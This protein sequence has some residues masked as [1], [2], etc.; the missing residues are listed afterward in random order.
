SSG[1]LAEPPI[2]L[3]EVQ[4]YAYGAKLA[5]ARL[6]RAMDDEVAAARLEAEAAKLRDEFERAFWCQD[7]GV[8][9]LALD[10]E[11]RPCK[12]RTSNTGHCLFAGIATAAHAKR[13]AAGFFEPDFFSGWGIRTLASGEARY[14]PLSYH[15]G[16]VWPHDNAVIAKGL[17]AY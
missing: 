8:Y 4:A 3:S 17:A 9:A 6:S 12:V 5:A 7:L 16:S 1:A 14:N 2:A 13:I 11:K 10:G 15:N